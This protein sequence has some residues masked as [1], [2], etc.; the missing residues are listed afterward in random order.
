MDANSGVSVD[1]FTDSVDAR[2]SVWDTARI[3]GGVGVV[4]GIGRAFEGWA[5]SLRDSLDLEQR[6]EMRRRL[7]PGR[8]RS[9]NRR[10][11]RSCFSWV[12]AASTARAAFD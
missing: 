6:V 3:T 2:V 9:S 11:R 5:L 4:A 8:V 7:S 10:S 1:A 12:W